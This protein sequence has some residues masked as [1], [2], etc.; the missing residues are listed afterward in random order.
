MYDASQTTLERAAYHSILDLTRV[1]SDLHYVMRCTTTR[2]ANSQIRTPPN[3]LR[4]TVK[5]RIGQPCHANPEKSE[6]Y[7]PSYYCLPATLIEDI[8]LF[9]VRNAPL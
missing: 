6:M 1:R 7:L 2:K 5:V 9:M 3:L 8:D 4:D